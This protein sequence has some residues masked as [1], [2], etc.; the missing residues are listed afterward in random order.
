MGAARHPRATVDPRERIE[1]ENDD[2]DEKD[3]F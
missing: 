2:G 1:N 3:L